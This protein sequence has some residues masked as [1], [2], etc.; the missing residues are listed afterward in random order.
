MVSNALHYSRMKFGLKKK[1]KKLTSFG[2]RIDFPTKR[3]TAELELCRIL[4]TYNCV[5]FIFLNL[6]LNLVI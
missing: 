2:C 6:R 3:C 1:G 5:V 4:Y